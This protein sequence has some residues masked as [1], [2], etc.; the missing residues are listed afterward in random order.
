MERHSDSSNT[1]LK[2][3]KD[4]KAH[5]DN[6]ILMTGD[7]NIR[8]SLWDPSFPFY[9]SISDD[10][11]LIADSFNLTFSNLTNPGPTRFSNMNGESNSIIDLIF[12]HYGSSKLDQYSIILESRLSSDHA[13]LSVI[14]P[15][16]R[17]VIQMSKLLLAPKSE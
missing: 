3:L 2:Y 6:V 5:I 12:L 7:F 1:A 13:P 10:L 4:T 11:V 17:E 16:F 9:S 14:I 15:L 8:D